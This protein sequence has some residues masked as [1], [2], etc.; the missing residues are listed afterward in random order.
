MNRASQLADGRLAPIARHRVVAAT[1]RPRGRSRSGPDGRRSRTAR[2]SGTRQTTP[3]TAIGKA[4]RTNPTRICGTNP[5]GR[6]SI[7]SLSEFSVYAKRLVCGCRE[8]PARVGG[9]GGRV[10]R[11]DSWR[12]YEMNP[13]DRSSTATLHEISTS[14]DI[15][16]TGIGP[17]MTSRFAVGRTA[18]T[19]RHPTAG[20]PRRS[21]SP[22]RIR[23]GF[24]D[25]TPEATG[26]CEQIRNEPN[27]H[28]EK[29]C[30]LDRLGMAFMRRGKRAKRSQSC[31]NGGS[32]S[33]SA[34]AN[35]RERS[36]RHGTDLGTARERSSLLPTA[37]GFRSTGRIG[38]VRSSDRHH[39]VPSR[40]SR[41]SPGND[42]E[43]SLHSA[44]SR[45]RGNR[46]RG[47]RAPRMMPVGAA[48]SRWP[49][50]H[51]RTLNDSLPPSIPDTG[52]VR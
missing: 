39:P 20:D 7:A 44:A 48:A 14:I 42:P 51:R 33:Q 17:R 11:T 16:R 40:P 28:P 47:L 1:S 22:H 52:G 26:T 21:D 15:G 18:R 27:V 9:A 32:S 43:P 49:D 34:K 38:G 4:G 10:I 19:S 25:V 35:A 31:Q 3:P 12:T 2:P 6:F 41:A 46:L 24:L 8:D 23:P 45:R 37:K 30:G 36:H 5:T 13:T 29:V 50:C